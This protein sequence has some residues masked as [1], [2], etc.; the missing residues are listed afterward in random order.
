MLQA[1]VL[2]QELYVIVGSYMRVRG[3]A[4][5]CHRIQHSAIADRY[6]AMARRRHPIN[7]ETSLVANGLKGALRWRDGFARPKRRA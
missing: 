2:M 4:F 5:C 6:H 7:S 1:A 3:I